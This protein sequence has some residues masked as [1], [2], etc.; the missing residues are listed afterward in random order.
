M[1]RLATVVSFAV[2]AILV[3]AGCSGG[4]STPGAAQSGPEDAASASKLQSTEAPAP[5][6]ASADEPIT[7]ESALPPTSEPRPNQPPPDSPSDQALSDPY[8]ARVVAGPIDYRQ[9]PVADQPVQGTF[10]LSE[11]LQL[12]GRSSDDAWLAVT[13]ADGKQR[14]VWIA[15]DA[16]GIAFSADIASLPLFASDGVWVVRMDEG[17]APPQATFFD[18]APDWAHGGS[19]LLHSDEGTL[20]AYDPLT[21]SDVPSAEVRGDF[22]PDGRFVLNAGGQLF[23]AAG[24]LVAEITLAQAGPPSFALGQFSWAPDSQAVLAWDQHNTEE[25]TEDGAPIRV[26]TLSGEARTVAFGRFPQWTAD[27]DILY[28]VGERVRR[29]SKDGT[30]VPFP[31]DIRTGWIVASPDGSLFAA[32][33]RGIYNSDGS[34]AAPVGGLTL[35]ASGWSPDGRRLV[36]YYGSSTWLVD[37]EHDLRVPIARTI[38]WQGAWSPDASRFAMAVPVTTPLPVDANPRAYAD[39]AIFRAD[40][41]LERVVTRSLGVVDIAW[42]PDGQ[43]LAFSSRPLCC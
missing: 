41:T 22:S 20:L 33:R 9:W 25:A 32:S 43:W 39:V 10:V 1:R 30:P 15:R 40:G 4:D 27:G 28:V 14:T 6:G 7:S 36:Y 26:V 38:P 13:F 37:V 24:S 17:D 21:R 8:T 42:S 34:L 35:T 19:V 18:G 31:A 16:G 3:T 12:L 5:T 2:A 23:D 11:E 29:V